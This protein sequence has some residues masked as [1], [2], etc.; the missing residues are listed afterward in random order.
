MSELYFI[1]G[2]DVRKPGSAKIH[3][4]LIHD[5]CRNV[6]VFPWTAPPSEKSKGWIDTYHK[7]FLD[8]GA[9]VVRFAD[10]DS[11]RE[12]ICEQIGASDLLYLPGGDPR[13]LGENIRSQ[14]V[15]SAIGAFDGVIAG[16]SAGAMVMSQRMIYL[17]G[18]DG[19]PETS[20]GEGLSLADISVSVHYGAENRLDAGY[21]PD[22][23]L[24]SIS[25]KRNIDVY[26]I[27]ETSAVVVKGNVISYYGEVYVFR[28]GNRHKIG[29]V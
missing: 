2:E 25:E 9:I 13:M 27:P 1:G 16:N 28:N 12:K 4:G 8:A 5:S 14:N 22:D 17:H 15:V 23:D 19:E 21:G 11:S 3:E 18:Q 10:L 24:A 6:L 26:A 7:F 29:A 20:V